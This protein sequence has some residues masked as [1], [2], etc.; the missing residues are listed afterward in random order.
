MGG[1]RNGGKI[2]I[3]EAGS[4]REPALPGKPEV[5]W[6]WK[7]F[8]RLVFLW[9]VKKGQSPVGRPGPQGQAFLGVLRVYPEILHKDNQNQEAL[10]VRVPVS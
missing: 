2:G 9:K 4:R 5:C 6:G 8:C 1:K 7:I 10:S 3:E